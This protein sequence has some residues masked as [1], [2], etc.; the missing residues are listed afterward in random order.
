MWRCCS[1][2]TLHPGTSL[3][4]CSATALPRLPCSKMGS[5]IAWPASQHCSAP[6][7]WMLTSKKKSAEKDD[8]K[9]KTNSKIRKFTKNSN[10]LK[11]VNN[12][13]KVEVQKCENSKIRKFE[14]SPIFDR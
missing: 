14:N 5:A 6:I 11:V 13:A 9:T 8:H 7:I 2:A 3:L 12:N 1:P 4:S 10:I